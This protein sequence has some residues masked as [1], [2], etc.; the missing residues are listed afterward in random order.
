MINRLNME[1]GVQTQ[2]HLWLAHP[3]EIQEQRLLEQ[4]EH[5]L[6]QQE[7][8]S[9]QQL[10]GADHR[11]EYL[12]SQAFLRSVLGHY[13]RC[14]PA[15]LEFER[16]ASGKPALKLAPD[17][18]T[19]LHFNLSHS[20]E[21]MACVVSGAGAVGVDVEPL[22]GDESMLSMAE[23]YFSVQELDALQALP[24][25]QQGARF[26]QVW[27]LKEAY[28]KARG[29]GLSIGLDAFSFDFAA[30]DSFSS[31]PGSS[32]SDRQ[33]AIVLHEHQPQRQV[34]D[35]QFWS[36]LPL[37]GHAVAI[38]L[39]AQESPLRV[40]SGIPLRDMTETGLPEHGLV[41]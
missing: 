7:R 33:A 18:L 39:Q 12:I 36:L 15:E 23:H 30:P 2:V 31:N 40:F 17:E 29:E 3:L 21:L 27:T 13:S 19:D 4:Y 32:P 6:S 9:Y 24:D 1:S 5:L 35:W 11:R 14:Q 26:K 28:I 8:D 34:T 22:N 38:A 37:S 20:S 41:A 16:N 25:A 10:V